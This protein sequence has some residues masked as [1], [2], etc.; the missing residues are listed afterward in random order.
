[1]FEKILYQVEEKTFR[2]QDLTSG[3]KVDMS[4]FVEGKNQRGKKRLQTQVYVIYK[5]EYTNTNQELD[6]LKDEVQHLKH[7]LNDKQIEIKRLEKQIMEKASANIDEVMQLKDEKYNIT[8]S[9][10]NEIRKLH[11]EKSNLEKSHLEHINKLKETHAN[12]LIAIDETHQKEIEKLH[13]HYNVKL[14]EANNKLLAEVQANK[15]S[16][17]NYQE[18]ILSIT[19]DH[20][21]EIDILHQEKSN[22]ENTHAKEKLELTKK[23]SY[24][25]EQLNEVISSLKQEHLQELN[26]K[27]KAH[28][29][30][31]EKIRNTFLKKSLSDNDEDVRDL[32]DL[33]DVNKFKKFIMR[34]EMKKIDEMLERKQSSANVKTVNA[35]IESGE[36]EKKT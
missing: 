9:H 1:M 15:Q 21:K 33:K 7:T 32:L 36:K 20:Q 17:D 4:K 19:Q 26:E 18:Q 35:Y 10:D 12:Q 14:D 29:D 11:Q 27:D 28:N 22:L 16:S 23:H 2:V 31:R 25:I 3:D 5:D 8:Q 30:E 34:N 24:D 13:S 6:T